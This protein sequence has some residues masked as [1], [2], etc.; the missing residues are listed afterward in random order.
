MLRRAIKKTKIPGASVAIV[1]QNGEVFQYVAGTTN[2][3]D[4]TP[5]TNTTIFEVASLSKPFSAYIFLKII[6]SGLFSKNGKFSERDFD[7]RLYKLAEFGPPHLRKDPCYESLTAGLILSHQAGLPNWFRDK[8]EF[9]AKPKERFDYSGIAYCFLC[10]VIET[11]SGKSFEKLAQEVF[12]K[13]DMKNSSFVQPS[14]EKLK[15]NPIAM[16][17]N[18][19]GISDKKEHFPSGSRPNPA[20]SL[21]TTAED[22]AKF[23]TACIHDPFIKKYMFTPKVA[24]ANIDNKAIDAHV[25]SKALRLIHWGMGSGLQIGKDGIKIAFHWGDIETSRSF[26]A[27]N[28]ETEQ[29]VV[30]LT[31]SANGPLIFRQVIEPVV[32]NLSPV[33]H[34]LER[35]E[36]LPFHAP[37]KLSELL[38]KKSSIFKKLEEEYLI[39]HRHDSPE[40]GREYDKRFGL[41]PT[42]K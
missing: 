11:V 7:K 27:I 24:L 13:L 25:S 14:E 12:D 9:I 35:R 2:N 10:E 34:W 26:F 21:F 33:F 5:I 41:L 37:V 20:A 30:C 19:E 32:G 29:A 16:G 8:E 31:N 40:I 1:N 22:Y 38:S 36:N 17:H 23:I 28:L 4:P 15:N 3:S 42:K 6:E 18:A 39:E